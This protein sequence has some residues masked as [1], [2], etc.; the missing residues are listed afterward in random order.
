MEIGGEMEYSELVSNVSRGSGGWGGVGR[1]LTT[2]VLIVYVKN[3][4]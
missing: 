2:Q 4:S 3:L 1:K